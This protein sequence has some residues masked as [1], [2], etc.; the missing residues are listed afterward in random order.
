MLTIEKV[1]VYKKYVGVIDG[2]LM[3]YKDPSQ[4]KI[5][6]DEWNLIDGLL[7]DTVIIKNNN[8]SQEFV[9]KFNR[10]LKDCCDNEV[11]IKELINLDESLKNRKLKLDTYLIPII[12][13][14]IRNDS[15]NDFTP[16]YEN[17]YIGYTSTK[18][19]IFEN[20]WRFMCW[21]YC[22]VEQAELT[23]KHFTKLGM[24]EV[25]FVGTGLVSERIGSV[26]LYYRV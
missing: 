6:V 20:K 19:I 16:V 11:T 18:K 22:K 14:I 5:S 7:Q 1:N 2:Y 23:I 26:F 21:K 10:Q 12:E 8:A 3:T 9:D 15:V 13:F 24:H 17:W 4:R 25:K